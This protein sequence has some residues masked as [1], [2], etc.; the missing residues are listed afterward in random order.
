MSRPKLTPQIAY[1]LARR[2]RAASGECDT[3]LEGAIVQDPW[4]AY[5]YA[6][7]VLK[8]PWPE[9][10]FAI[11]QDAETA[12]FY[13]HD[14]LKGP[15]PEAETVIAQD[16]QYARWYFDDVLKTPE[17]KARFKRVQRQVAKTK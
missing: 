14:L 12:Y 3:R 10:E 17:D 4:Y 8:A 6:F 1:N 15:W 9:G 7:Y 16:P 13:A 2:L 11:V 5:K